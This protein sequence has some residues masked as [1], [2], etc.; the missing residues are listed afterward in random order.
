MPTVMMRP[1]GCKKDGLPKRNVIYEF[2]Q[3]WSCKAKKGI[4]KLFHQFRTTH[5]KFLPKF[6]GWSKDG[7]QM[8]QNNNNNKKNNT[9]TDQKK[10]GF[11]NLLLVK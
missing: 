11:G 2:S 7:V 6:S 3:F 1:R 4:F 10:S 8:M 5:L 9:W